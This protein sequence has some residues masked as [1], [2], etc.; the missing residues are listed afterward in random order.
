MLEY[1]IY[2]MQC[3][4]THQVVRIGV[5]L[6]QKISQDQWFELGGYDQDVLRA[7]L[8]EI[9]R[10][11]QL[12]LHLKSLEK[13]LKVRDEV[14]DRGDDEEGNEKASGPVPRREVAVTH[15]THGHHD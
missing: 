11:V 4:C 8:L 9:H 3:S 7:R 1:Y 2:T 14:D 6:C 13:F 12:L 10:V 15:R 5:K